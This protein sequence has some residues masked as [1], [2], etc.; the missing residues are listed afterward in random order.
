MGTY[1]ATSQCREYSAEEE[2]FLRA[3]EQYR[4]DTGAR[5]LTATEYLKVLKSLG[6]SKPCAN[7]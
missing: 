2:A 6:Y 7:T 1:A 4:S 3:C 5:F